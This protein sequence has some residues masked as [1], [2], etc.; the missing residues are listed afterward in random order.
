MESSKRRKVEDS[1]NG[2]DI[3]VLDGFPASR[4]FS[5]VGSPMDTGAPNGSD[6]L[7]LLVALRCRD[8]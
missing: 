7:D 1:A 6:G 5:Q 2:D 8:F 4:L 3:E